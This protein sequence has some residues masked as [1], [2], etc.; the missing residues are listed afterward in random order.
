M[1]G[2][3]PGIIYNIKTITHACLYGFL[4]YVYAGYR[5]VLGKNRQL[6]TI[7]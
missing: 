2:G 1:P 3:E 5:I 4:I 7:I 6:L